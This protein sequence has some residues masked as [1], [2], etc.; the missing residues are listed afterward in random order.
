MSEKDWR[1]WCWWCEKVLQ[2]IGASP[3]ISVVTSVQIDPFG[4]EPVGL[5]GH[6]AFVLLRIVIE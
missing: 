3:L 5:I 2:Q 6:G 1:G 4:H